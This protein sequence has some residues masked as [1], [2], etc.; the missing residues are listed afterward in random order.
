MKKRS[1]FTVLEVLV[2][3]VFTALLFIIFLVQKTNIDASNRD[4]DR[5]IA[6]NAMYYALENVFYANNNYYP[7]AISEANLNYFDPALWTDPL[8]YNLGVD[9]SS[10]TYEPINCENEHCKGYILKAQLE[11]EDNYVKRNRN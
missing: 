5:K 6:I 4:T 3:G 7:E 11:K 1:G 10:Y 8:G 2:V 9:G